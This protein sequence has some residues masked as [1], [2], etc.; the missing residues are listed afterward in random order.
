MHGQQNI[1]IFLCYVYFPYGYNY[2]TSTLFWCRVW[3]KQ[4]RNY[5]LDNIFEQGMNQEH[6][7]SPREPRLIIMFKR[8]GQEILYPDHIRPKF[9]KIKFSGQSY[10]LDIITKFV[11]IHSVILEIKNACRHN[12]LLS[13]C[14]DLIN[15]TKT[16]NRNFISA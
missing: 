5:L 1:N 8:T 15:F 3:I 7:H 4:I 9:T 14:V 2:W 11:K 13:I 6:T 10:L 16:L 12:T